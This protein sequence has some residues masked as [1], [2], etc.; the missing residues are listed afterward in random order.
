MLETNNHNQSWLDGRLKYQ[1]LDLN[2]K[3]AMAVGYYSKGKPSFKYY[4]SDGK[5]D[6]LCRVWHENGQLSKEEVF[7][8]GKLLLSREWFSNGQMKSE[9]PYRNGMIHGTCRVWYEN[10]QLY[11]QGEYVLHMCH[12]VTA[13]WYPGGRL[14]SRVK[15]ESGLPHGINNYW[16]ESGKLPGKKVFIRGVLITNKIHNLVNS[17]ELTAKHILGI[18]NAAVRRVCLGELGYEKFLAQLEHEVMDRKGDYELMRINWYK[19]EEP[20]C[21]VKVKCHSTKVF[22]TLRVP[23]SM[24]TVREAVAWTFGMKHKEY[25]PEEEA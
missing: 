20:I 16:D 2:A 6:G 1:Y 4:L 24:R 21:L 5:L 25:S 10:G 12:G 14:K 11:S 19:R 3:K 23:P 15:F 9:T 13:R 7:A 17:G 18:K 22:Y 8:Q